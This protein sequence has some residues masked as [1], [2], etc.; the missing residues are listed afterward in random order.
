MEDFYFSSL[1]QLL[2]FHSVAAC[3]VGDLSEADKVRATEELL[4][5]WHSL[6]LNS[7]RQEK[8]VFH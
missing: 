4:I 8:A 6:A 3:V 1:I 2:L 5:I 7:S